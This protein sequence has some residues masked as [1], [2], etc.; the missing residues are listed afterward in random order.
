MKKIIIFICLTSFA[1]AST[2]HIAVAANVSYTIKELVKEFKKTNPNINIKVSSAS[3]GKLTAQIKNYAPYQLFMSA[4]MFYP[5]EAK[6][7][8][9]TDSRKYGTYCL[10]NEW[11]NII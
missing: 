9:W 2:I 1:F 8:G 6:T 4:N 11:K 10:T 3:S 7:K 5:N